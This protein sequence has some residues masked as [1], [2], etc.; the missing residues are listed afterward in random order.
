MQTYICTGGYK[1]EAGDLGT[2]RIVLPADS[3]EMAMT[4]AEWK[5]KTDRRRKYFGSMD[6]SCSL[7]EEISND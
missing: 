3:F 6:M 5:I 7:Y 2:F 1:T 4:V